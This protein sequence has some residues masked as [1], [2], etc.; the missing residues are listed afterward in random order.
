MSSDGQAVHGLLEVPAGVLVEVVPQHEAP[1]VL[2]PGEELLELE[3]H[4]AAVDPE[5]DDV[6]L[7]LVGDAPHHLGALQHLTTSRTV[8]R[9]S[10]SSADRLLDTSSS[11]LR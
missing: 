3:A 1:V 9:S 11:R 2:D 7:D 5:L 6:A 8:T 4:Q 10:I